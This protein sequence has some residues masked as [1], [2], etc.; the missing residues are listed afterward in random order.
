[1]VA[2]EVCPDG[3]PDHERHVWDVG[4]E[5]QER[6]IQDGV[7]QTTP[8]TRNARLRLPANHQDDYRDDQSVELERCSQDEESSSSLLGHA[9]VD[10]GLAPPKEMAVRGMPKES[11][12]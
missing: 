1:V 5:G 9:V 4:S 2:N 6:E 11:P 7:R 12:P 3:K 8:T 10:E